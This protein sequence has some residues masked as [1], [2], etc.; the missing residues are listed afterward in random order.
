MSDD[1][2]FL[3][4]AP[5][6][7]QVMVWTGVISIVQI[8]VKQWNVFLGI[9]EKRLTLIATKYSCFAEKEEFVVYTCLCKMLSIEEKTDYFFC[10]KT[11]FIC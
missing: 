2:P 11:N 7:G 1:K 4:T 9:E 8:K 10:V 3:C 6:C 5:G